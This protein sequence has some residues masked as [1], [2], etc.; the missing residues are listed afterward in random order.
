[1]EKVGDTIGPYVI[2]D[3]IGTGGMGTVF[4]ATDQR[5][6]RPVAIKSLLNHLRRDTE[7]VKRFKSEAVAQARLPHPNIVTVHDFITDDEHM[8]MV[9]EYIEGESLAALLERAGCPLP[10]NQSVDIMVQVLG[11]I[12]HAHDHGVVHRDIKPSNILVSD[13]SG[14]TIAKVCDFGVAKILGNEK[15]RTATQAKMGTLAYM[16]PEQVKSPRSVDQ[17]TDIY[18]LGATLFEMLTGRA[19]FTSDSEYGMMEAI[20]QTPVARPTEILDTLPNWVND[21]ISKAMAKDPADRFETCG[22][23]RS[24]LLAVE[25]V[26]SP[27]PVSAATPPPL[28]GVQPVAPPKPGTGQQAPPPSPSPA[29]EKM[30]QAGESA[31]RFAKGLQ[32]G[33]AKDALSRLNITR[34]QFKF[35]LKWAGVTVVSGALL[36]SG[37]RS[38]AY[39][40]HEV[41]LAFALG[42]G[43]GAG[44][45]F[46]LKDII[47]RAYLWPALTVGAMLFSL[48]TGRAVLLSALI[49]GAAQCVALRPF[50]L[51]ALWWLLAVVLFRYPE[52]WKLRHGGAIEGIVWAAIFQSALIAWIVRPRLPASE[53]LFKAKGSEAD[54]QSGPPGGA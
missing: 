45:W 48:I 11:A 46:L 24:A 53:P 2:E 27:S 36:S 16:S 35:A 28:I 32:D 7:V 54:R 37:I 34:E 50:G 52:F 12:A 22:E 25:G 23:F 39:N 15:F 17:R 9:L 20:I 18:S 5:F 51:R 42:V 3:A 47:P 10:L 44:P 33:G 6:N 30:R 38:G 41:L 8:C 4:K 14:E 1:M 40:W 21:V 19:P 26:S 29:E 49:M 31:A 13:L 43:A